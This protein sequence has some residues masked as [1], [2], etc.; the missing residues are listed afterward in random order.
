MQ[1]VKPDQKLVTKQKVPYWGF[2]VYNYVFATLIKQSEILIIGHF[3]HNNGFSVT[4]AKV[5]FDKVHSAMTDR[6]DDV[7]T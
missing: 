4:L 2:F 5:L 3:D 7:N 6:S 1:I